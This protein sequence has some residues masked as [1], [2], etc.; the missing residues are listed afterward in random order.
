[1][2]EDLG[3]IRRHRPGFVLLDRERFARL[4]G[5][6]AHVADAFDFPEFEHLLIAGPE[7]EAGDLLQFRR[8]FDF[9]P[10]HLSA[11]GTVWSLRTLRP[12]QDSAQVLQEEE[13]WR[14]LR[15]TAAGIFRVDPETIELDSSTENTRGWN[16]L[17]YI[18]LIMA[19]EEAFGRSLAPRDI[20]TVRQLRDLVS[21]L[22]SAQR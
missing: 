8:I 2:A 17:A 20:M 10:E 1:V 7:P 19:I 6:E 21:I 4:A 9:D 15:K 3:W 11:L 18:Q 12:K 13:I 22:G 16:S 5:T 14:I